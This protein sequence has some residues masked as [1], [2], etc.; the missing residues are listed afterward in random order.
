MFKE[1]KSKKSKREIRNR[2]YSHSIYAHDM[3][4]GG[5]AGILHRVLNINDE[6]SNILGAGAFGIVTSNKKSAVKLFY[7]RV[8]CKTIYDEARIQKKARNLLEGIVHVPRVHTVYSHTTTYRGNQ[9]LCGIAMDRVPLVNTF[10][11]AVHILLGYNQYDI[12][13]EWG[14]DYTKPVGPNNPSRG[15]FA[16]A[17]MLEAIWEDE[18]RSDIS[19]DSVAYTMGVAIAR[20]IM[21]GIAP[22]DMEWIYG[23]DGQIYLIDFGMCEERVVDP[24]AYLNHVG[25]TGMG[26][27]YY[28][29]Q[30]GFRGYEAFQKGFYDVIFSKV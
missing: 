11:V 21:G 18:G 16:C 17:E 12:D 2:V 19:I 30:K 8:N 26:G 24:V 10:N 4:K 9:Y 27:D 29:P 25:S 20:L 13:T 1:R 22:Y 15:F 5:R 28:I 6:E 23:G 3:H 14:R 7:D